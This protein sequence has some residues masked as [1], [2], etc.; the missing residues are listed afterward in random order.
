M[1]R[2]REKYQWHLK[3]AWTTEDKPQAQTDSR[4]MIPIPR[5]E[6]LHPFIMDQL[7]EQV[8]DI[9]GGAK[10][11]IELTLQS[12]NAPTPDPALL[13]PHQSRLDDLREYE[14]KVAIYPEYG[15][16][17]TTLRRELDVLKKHVDDVYAKWTNAT[18]TKAAGRSFTNS[19]IETRQDKLRALSKVFSRDPRLEVGTEYIA[20]RTFNERMEFKAS[21][22]YH[23]HPH[24]RFPWDVATSTLCKLKAASAPGVPR[25]VVQYMHD[26]MRVVDR[27]RRR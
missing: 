23:K 12:L 4:N 19:P 7:S 17:A 14:D 13:A 26:A 10:R 21:Y 20:L 11:K 6:G 9:V 2:D 3:P 16:Y 24:Q 5:G 22:A 25:T 27:G 8:R 15:S 18:R 1:K